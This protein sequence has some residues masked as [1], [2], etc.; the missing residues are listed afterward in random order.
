MTATKLEGPAAGAAALVAALARPQPSP[1]APLLLLAVLIAAALRGY[2]QELRLE[3]KPDMVTNEAEVGDPS[4]LVDEQREI[5]GPPAGKPKTT[6]ELNS[7]YWKQ[8][9]FSAHLDL[10]EAKNL[11]SLWIYDTNGKGD[12]VISA[13]KPGAWKEVATYDC[14]TYLAWAEVKLDVT[15]R[16]LRSTRKTPGANFTEIAVYE[17]TDEAHQAMLARKAEA[18]RQEAERQAALAKA[19]QEAL[20]R[21]LVEVPP[22]GTLSLV[23]E[24]VCS[25]SGTDQGGFG[26]SKR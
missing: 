22:Y 10:G 24:I 13:G 2:A 18:A 20:R 1:A 15:T 3:L 14:G 12:V 19:R 21:P 6:W 5:I 11:S 4:G 9:P 8:F 23:D 7:R 17:Y 16:Y 26:G 25:D